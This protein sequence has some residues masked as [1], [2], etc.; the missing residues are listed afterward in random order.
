MVCTVRDRSEQL[1]CSTSPHCNTAPHCE[2]IS[3]LME[4]D[5]ILLKTVTALLFV[6]VDKSTVT[7]ALCELQ[8]NHTSNVNMEVDEETI[9]ALQEPAFN[10]C[11]KV[12]PGTVSILL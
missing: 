2:L 6:V 10:E 5:N 9:N 3:K 11:L 7:N 4:G 8:E 1:P 12:C